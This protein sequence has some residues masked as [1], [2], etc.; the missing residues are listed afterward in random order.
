MPFLTS[1]FNCKYIDNILSCSSINANKRYCL[2]KNL[3]F[4][5]IIP[6]KGYFTDKATDGSL[7]TL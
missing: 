7:E 3:Y 4:I 2:Q 6:V 5:F 1:Y